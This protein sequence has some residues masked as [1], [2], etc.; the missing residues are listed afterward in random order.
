M[1]ER[2]I[3]NWLTKTNERNYQAAFCQVLMQKGHRVLY[4]SSHGPMEQGKDIITVGS[5]GVYHAFQAKTGDIGLKEWRSIAGEIQE[6]LEL[7]I[8]YPGVDKSST[9]RAYLV[10]NGSITDPVRIQINDRNEDNRRKGRQYPHLEVIGADSLLKIFVD[11]QGRF[12]PRELPDMRAFLEIYLEDGR[13]MLPKEKMFA[14]LDSTSFGQSPVK[15]SD[16]ADAITSS[17]IIVSYLLNS[18]EE[19]ENY[20]AMAEGW[21]ILAACMARYVCRHAIPEDQWRTSLDLVVAEIDANL[22]LLRNDAL[23]RTD[24][25]EDD[26]LGDGGAMLRARTSIVLGAL[27]CHE[28]LPAGKTK[29][30]RE[31]EEVLKLIRE[32][33]SRQG[34]WGDSAFPYM[35]CTI[36]FLEARNERDLARKMLDDLFNSLVEANCRQR[37]SVFPGLYLGVEDVLAA[38]IPDR[39][40]NADFE[41]YRGSSYVLRAILEMLVRRGRRDLLGEVWPQLTYCQQHEFIPDR[42]EDIFAWQTKDGKN[43]SRFPNQTQ[44]WESLVSESFD[45]SAIPELYKG[46]RQ[47]LQFHIL[48]C[49]H[50]AT[51]AVIRMLD[52]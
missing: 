23:S 10:T 18:F 37:G 24:F 34:Y 45:T 47:V 25:L 28:L 42:T 8:D 32:H 2:A 21:S 13:G 26:I 40:H 30:D 22:A 17:L 44:S 39:L 5:D 51:P 15:K 20:Y 50:R 7:P 9:H 29:T 16:A 3:E 11:A 6:L 33:I 46:F 52:A 1:I 35:F 14:V 38:S 36:K 4:S 19:S 49:P 27:A 31:P 48:V 43:A 12:V 41:G